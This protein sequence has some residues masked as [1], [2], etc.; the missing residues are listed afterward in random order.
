LCQVLPAT[1]RFLTCCN[2]KEIRHAWQLTLQ[3]AGTVRHHMR[4]MPL[5]MAGG[6]NRILAHCSYEPINL[7]LVCPQLP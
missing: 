6:P 5:H 4:R 7:Y 2:Q 1:W 3:A